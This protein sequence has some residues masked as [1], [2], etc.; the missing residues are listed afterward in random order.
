MEVRWIDGLSNSIM[1]ASISTIEIEEYKEEEDAKRTRAT[2]NV[3][4]KEFVIVMHVR[5]SLRN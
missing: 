4:I 1:L 3:N 2:H 5:I